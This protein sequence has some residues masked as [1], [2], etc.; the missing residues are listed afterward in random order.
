MTWQAR[1]DIAYSGLTPAQVATT[2]LNNPISSVVYAVGTIFLGFHLWH[3]FYSGFQTLGLVHPKYTPLIKLI[4]YI[5]AVVIA[6]GFC[7]LPVLYPALKPKADVM[8]AAPMHG[9]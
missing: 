3:G 1:P 7:S 8:N 6:I 9:H 4:G 5:F 2:V